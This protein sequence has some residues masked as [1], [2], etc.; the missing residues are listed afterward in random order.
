MAAAAAAWLDALEPAQRAVATGGVRRARRH[1]AV[2]L[3][4]RRPPRVAEQ[5]RRG[6]RG[7]RHDA[8]LLRRRPGVLSAARPGAAAPAGRGRG[9]GPRADPLARPGPGGPGGT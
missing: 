7:A 2:G 8:V 9:S 1:G 4:V 3:A 6:R 5:P